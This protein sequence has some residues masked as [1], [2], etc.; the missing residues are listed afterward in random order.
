MAALC[1]TGARMRFTEFKLI[2]NSVLN[3]KG[4]REAYGSLNE[5]LKQ[6]SPGQY[7]EED[8]GLVKQIQGIL[9]NLGY[10][11][12]PTGADGKYG[13]NTA[14]AIGN[15]KRDYKLQG[16][17]SVFGEK[18]LQTIE[19]IASGAI[20]PVKPFLGQKQRSSQAHSSAPKGTD[21]FKDIELSQG[22]GSGRVRI[23]TSGKVRNKPIAT[24]LMNILKTAADEAKVDVVVFS[25]GQDEKGTSGASRTGSIR[26]DNGLAADIW[27]YSDGNRLRTDN[28]DPVVAKFIAAAVAAGAKGIGAGPGYMNSV[29]IHIDLW[30]DKAG[31]KTWGKGGRS[32]ATPTY[33]AQAYQAGATGIA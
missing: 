26:H 22:S 18:S 5:E 13:V 9:I 10:D 15:F 19:K 7:P 32:A 24:S 27:L 14:R 25:G 11:L 4:L 21:N 28:A 29:G 6:H 16:P 23:A 17:G 12:G 20:K 8:M 3:V 1:L 31:S 2:E 33:V 30:G